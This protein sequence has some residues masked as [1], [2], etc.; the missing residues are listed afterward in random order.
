[1]QI[2]NYLIDSKVGQY[3]ELIE[4]SKR[5]SQVLQKAYADERIFEG[6]EFIMHGQPWAI[7][8][9][10]LPELH[11]FR[12]AAQFMSDEASSID[13]V[14]AATFDEYSRRFGQ[15]NRLLHP[16]VIAGT[17]RLAM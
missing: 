10:A 2:S 6:P 9:S 15:P 17:N 5:E 7:Y 4:L 3:P 1:M 8:V 13:E 14:Y 16:V 11:I 12:V